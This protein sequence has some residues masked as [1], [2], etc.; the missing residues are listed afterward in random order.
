MPVI[1]SKTDLLNRADLQSGLRRLP[2]YFVLDF[3]ESASP[4]FIG[5]ALSQVREIVDGI[6]VMADGKF[7]SAPVFYSVIVYRANAL[8][9]C[10]LS[11]PGVYEWN[12]LQ[13]DQ[14][15]PD[16]QPGFQAAMAMLQ[17][18]IE[19][20]VKPGVEGG[21]YRPLVYWFSPSVI[22]GAIKAPNSAGVYLCGA[23][24]SGFT[25]AWT[26]ILPFPCSRTALDQI[27]K[28]RTDLKNKQQQ[29][30]YPTDY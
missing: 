27:E 19:R 15:K 28:D 6:N 20:E 18:S 12:E 4:A 16:G 2:I 5:Q 1:P 21:D 26:D 10:P 11:P 30:D 17:K 7:A 23:A 8:Q 25:G 14:I 22:P 29:M 24:R 13:L 3:S 9:L